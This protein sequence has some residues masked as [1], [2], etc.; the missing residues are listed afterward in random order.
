MIRSDRNG[1]F[2]VALPPSMVEGLNQGIAWAFAADA[3][4][5]FA[6][7]CLPVYPKPAA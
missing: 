5:T 6:V 7:W 2:V 4:E 3:V 1:Y